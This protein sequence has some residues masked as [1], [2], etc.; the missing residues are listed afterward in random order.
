MGAEV[1]GFQVEGG[2]GDPPTRTPAFPEVE[3]FHHGGTEDTEREE[4][5]REDK[6]GGNE[7]W[8]IFSDLRYTQVQC[9]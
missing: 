7:G 1:Q 8:K 9:G 6:L 3:D 5:G 2:K 4:G